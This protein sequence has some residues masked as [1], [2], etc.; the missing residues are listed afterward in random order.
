[1]SSSTTAMPT[2]L[3]GALVKA[4]IARSAIEAPRNTHTSPVRV[5]STA[6]SSASSAT[7]DTL[8]TVRLWKLLGLAGLA[9]V[10][11]GGVVL[12]RNER[13]RRAYT[14]DDVRARLHERA[15]ALTETPAPAPDSAELTGGRMHRLARVLRRH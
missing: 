11:A 12:A 7:G 5:S 9:G 8:R 3:T 4:R 15:A 10:A 14:P 6:W 13:Q 2:W 1:M